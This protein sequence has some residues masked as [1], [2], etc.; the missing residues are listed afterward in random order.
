MRNEKT[1]NIGF[2]VIW[3]NCYILQVK[4]I[5]ETIKLWLTNLPDFLYSEPQQKMTAQLGIRLSKARPDIRNCS[6]ETKENTIR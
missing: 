4:M 1:D 3:P 6:K 5:P 2:Q